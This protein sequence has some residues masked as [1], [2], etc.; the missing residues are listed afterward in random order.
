MRTNIINR[1]N[2]PV[3]GIR[4]DRVV[5]VGNDRCAQAHARLLPAWHMHVAMAWQAVDAFKRAGKQAFAAAAAATGSS[6]PVTRTRL[7]EPVMVQLVPRASVRR[8]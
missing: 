6:Y 8:G 4:Q 5:T 7:V 1:T 2:T 3:I